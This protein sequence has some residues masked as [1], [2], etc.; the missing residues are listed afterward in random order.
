MT[1]DQRKEI[2][3]ML[4]QIAEHRRKRQEIILGAL[5]EIAQII[6]NGEQ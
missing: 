3:A 1:T 2:F 5:W 6:A 4:Q